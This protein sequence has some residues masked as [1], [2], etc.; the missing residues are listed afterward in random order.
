MNDIEVVDLGRINY[1]D[2]LAK[3]QYYAEKV[4]TEHPYR[5]Y[6]LLCEHDHVYTL[7]KHGGKQRFS[8]EHRSEFLQNRPW[9]RHHLSR[10]GTTCSISDIELKQ[11]EYRR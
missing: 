11:L 2:A 6:I 1:E 5:A 10:A 4:Q 9:G 7:G 8:Q 3:Q